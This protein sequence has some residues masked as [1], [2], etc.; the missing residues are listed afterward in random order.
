MSRLVSSCFF[1]GLWCPSRRVSCLAWLSPHVTPK[2]NTLLDTCSS[3]FLIVFFP[4]CIRG[5]FQEF[6]KRH[7]QALIHS[8]RSVIFEKPLQNFDYP[9]IGHNAGALFSLSYVRHHLALAPRGL[10]AHSKSVESRTR[11]VSFFITL[12]QDS[13]RMHSVR[14]YSRH[15]IISF[16][17]VTI[18]LSFTQNLI[19]QGDP[20][21]MSHPTKFDE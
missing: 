7:L 21:K 15:N 18:F 13:R 9:C 8:G 6:S 1:S 11:T 17:S 20:F 10:R 14:V 16:I 4:I 5:C 12:V 3:L 19:V 2:S